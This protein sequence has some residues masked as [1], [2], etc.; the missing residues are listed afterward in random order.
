MTRSRRA[1]HPAGQAHLNGREK[2]LGRRD[3]RRWPTRAVRVATS[4]EDASCAL[5]RDSVDSAKSA[6]LVHGAGHVVTQCPAHGVEAL[7][8][9]Q[10]DHRHSRLGV[11][12]EANE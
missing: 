12:A 1:W 9:V 4:T 10:L 5:Q 7:R 3:K 8:I 2:M 6:Q 11:N